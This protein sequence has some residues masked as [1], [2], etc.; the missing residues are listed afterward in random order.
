[1]GV[2]FIKKNYVHSGILNNVLSVG[3]INTIGDTKS[4]LKGN[5]IGKEKD[6]DKFTIE[7]I[8]LPKT[9]GKVEYKLELEQSNGMI[10][11]GGIGMEFSKDYNRNMNISIS[12]GYKF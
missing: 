3:V 11:S 12:V 6:G 1:M 7:G 4:N 10:Y 5:I 2:D 9:S 8:E